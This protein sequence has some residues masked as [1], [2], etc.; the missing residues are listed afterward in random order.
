MNTCETCRYW[1]KIRDANLG[2]YPSPHGEC[3]LI[4]DL[5]F[6]E[7]TWIWPPSPTPKDC[8]DLSLITKPEFG[9]NQWEQSE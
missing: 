7:V 9:C 3:T 1:R 5:S 2:N 4:N 6:D 8:E